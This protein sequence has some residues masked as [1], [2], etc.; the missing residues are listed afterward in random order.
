MSLNELGFAAGIQVNRSGKRLEEHAGAR[1]GY[2]CSSPEQ[3][4]N[5][6]QTEGGRRSTGGS[7]QGCY[8]ELKR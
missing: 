2:E 8:T 5:N 3:V 4:P 1:S 6:A 7:W